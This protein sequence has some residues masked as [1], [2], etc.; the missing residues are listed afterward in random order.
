MSS[1]SAE[2]RRQA[3]L[4]LLPCAALPPAAAH[5]LCVEST[6]ARPPGA[7]SPGIAAVVAPGHGVEPIEGRSKGPSVERPSD[8][9]GAVEPHHGVKLGVFWIEERRHR[10][11]AGLLERADRG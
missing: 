10:S 7:A 11:E 9:T 2:P 3:A 6:Q 8:S 4:L 1:G 5:L